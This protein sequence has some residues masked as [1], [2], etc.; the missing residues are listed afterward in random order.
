MDPDT[1]LD[2]FY[3]KIY[4]VLAECVPLKNDKPEIN[5]RY[6][7]PVWYTSQI[8]KLIQMKYKW[9]KKYKASKLQSDYDEFSRYRAIVK[10]ETALA[11]DRYRDHVQNHLASDPKAFWKFIK[12]KKGNSKKFKLEKNGRTLSNEECA[13]EFAQFFHS[14]YKVEPAQ[15]DVSAI[16]AAVG[17]NARVH[18]V[19]LEPDDVHRALA[20]LPPKISVGP[21]G[22]PPF[23]LK[24]CRH[25]L[26][27]PLLHV[28]NVC[29]ATATFPERW[30]LTRVVPVPKGSGGLETGDY[31][32]VALLNSPAKV[33]ESAIHHSL[34]G[35]VRAR[36]SDAQ[37]GFRPGRGT[38]GNLLHL[39]TQVVPALDAGRQ[40]DVAY[41][42][43]RK[44]FDTVDNDILL[45]KLAGIGCTPHTLTFLAR[46]LRDK[47]QYVDCAGC[48]SDQY[49]TRSG[50][51]QGSNLGPLQF[52]IM[53]ND[54]PEVVCESTCLLFADD[55]KLVREIGDISDHAKLQ[56]DIDKVI[57][58]SHDNKLYFNVAK[59]SIMSFSRARTPQHHPYLIE[60]EPLKRVT[61]V[62]DLGVRFTTDLNFREH[63]TGICKKAYRNLGFVLR[64]S[65]DFTNI[66]ALRVL[67]ETWVK[68]HLEYNSELY[69]LQV[70]L[71][72]KKW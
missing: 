66:K 68:S 56:H 10:A 19:R 42:D 60:G 65:H 15:L 39:M 53:I 27:E 26:K 23:I 43:F 48:H 18:L 31:R 9:H 63:I 12:S 70:K 33:F 61:E 2:N 35:Q 64:Q 72:I 71:N 16:S 46:Y 47:R 34:Y 62:R 29:L 36:L 52:I 67:Y 30:K 1:V 37:H 6:F 20:R 17:G 54:L 21:D 45:A 28:F 38:T 55:L 8:I 69:G 44:A 22:L 59:C 4:G 24:D 41:F 11:H 50:V 49:W 14:V 58:W 32:P 51:S 25:V 3:N 13:K 7:Y 40:V 5:V 57:K